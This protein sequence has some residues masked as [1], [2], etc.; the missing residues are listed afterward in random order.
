MG[1][2]D[3]GCSVGMRMS[4]FCLF[5][6][7]LVTVLA[8]A[9]SA[10]SLPDRD[11]DGMPDAWESRMGLNPDENDAQADPD[12]D[13]LVNLEEYRNGGNPQDGDSDGDLLGDGQEV[14]TYGTS[15]ALADTDSGGHTDGR[16]VA[17]GRNPLDGDDDGTPHKVTIDLEPGWNLVSLPVTP[18]SSAITD[19]LAPLSGKYTA[20]WSYRGDRWLAHDPRNPGFSDLSILEPGWGYWINMTETDRLVVVGAR[21][22]GTV[23]MDAD[24]NL[25]GFNPHHPETIGAALEGILQNCI[26]VW[27]YEGGRWRVYDP[28]SPAMSDLTMM[29]PGKGYWINM[30]R[31]CVWVQQ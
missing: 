13:G 18:P 20:V 15:P 8:G 30:S 29:N 26:A 12:Y 1:K 24:W 27:T 9:A 5:L 6:L 28:R 10:A 16:E 23:S 2:K 25:V 7:F 3:F 14:H 11:G 31:S 21:A 22:G 17:D 19:V 4:S